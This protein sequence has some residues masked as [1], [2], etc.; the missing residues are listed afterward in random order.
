MNSKGFFCLHT[1]DGEIDK[2]NLFWL[3]DV[4]RGCDLQANNTSIIMKVYHLA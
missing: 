3:L 1:I 4:V 2:L